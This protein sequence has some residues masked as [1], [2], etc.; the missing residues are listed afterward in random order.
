MFTDSRDSFL[1]N[2]EAIG[3]VCIPLSPTEVGFKSF[4]DGKNKS[5]YCL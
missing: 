5:Q 1:K 3:M 2:P 4:F